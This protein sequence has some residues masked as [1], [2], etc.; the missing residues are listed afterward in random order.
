MEPQTLFPGPELGRPL[1]AYMPTLPL[2]L[3]ANRAARVWSTMSVWEQ[4]FGLS[5]NPEQACTDRTSNH[6]H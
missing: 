1:T 4:I 5:T 6:D 2:A 3:G